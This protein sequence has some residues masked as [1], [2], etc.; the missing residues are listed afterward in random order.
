MNRRYKSVRPIALAFTL[1]G[2]VNAA[3]AQQLDV[4]ELTDYE[5]SLH[6]WAWCKEVSSST[7]ICEFG[8][9]DILG[10]SNL[11]SQNER[12]SAEKDPRS[13]YLRASA[14]T[15]AALLLGQIEVTKQVPEKCESDMLEILRNEYVPN[16]TYLE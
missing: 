1:I 12:V 5:K 7:G 15:E 9:F 14:D 6:R 3:V 2:A 10:I 4:N 16:F 8:C 13:I 11:L